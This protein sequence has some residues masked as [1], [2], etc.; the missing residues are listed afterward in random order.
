MYHSSIFSIG[1]PALILVF[2]AATPANQRPH[3][4]VPWKCGE[5]YRLS[6]THGTGSHRGKGKYGWDFSMPVG[7]PLVAPADGVVRAVRQDSTRHGCNSS[8]AYDGNYVI[9]AFEDGTEAL[10]L[11]LKADSVPVS[12]G[13]HVRAGDP[14]GQ[15]GMSG[16]TCGAH[17]HFQ[18]QR[19]C[20]SW[21]CQSIPAEFAN[22]EA[23][24]TGD[25]LT[26]KNCSD[27]T[28][29]ASQ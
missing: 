27:Q 14:I 7:T 28:V 23:P 18:I 6:Q 26:S 12:A 29:T 20:D 13:D 5:T 4:A 8:F 11:H 9:I 19:T 17:L 10:F 16:W 2:L 1:L 24:T 25:R 21:W 15:V 22:W 3:L